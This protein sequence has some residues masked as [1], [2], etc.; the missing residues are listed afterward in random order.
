MIRFGT[1]KSKILQKLTDAYASGN[2][3]EM[4]S[5]LQEVAKNK[6]F[7]DLYLFYEDIENK[8]IGNKEDAELFIEEI[9]P[10]LREQKN[11]SNKF[12][13]ELDKKLGDISITEN[14]VYLFLDK[15]SEN[16][17]LKNVHA[18]INA[19]NKLVEHLMKEK[20]SDEPV[21]TTF[22][23]N[24]NLLHAVL[25]N[26]FNVLY[27]STLNEEEKKLLKEIL[28]I[29]DEDLKNNFDTLKEEVSNKVQKLVSEEKN[30]EVLSKL[31]QV[32]DEM[33]SMTVSKFNYYKLSQLKNG[34]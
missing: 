1:L 9:T 17:T 21:E 13:K 22:A 34:L 3:T 31:T 2:R 25:A 7:R 6:S 27:E 32:V 15:I 18:K 19:K 4:K 20:K 30:T 10:L 26:N 5:L 24:E 28:S 11:R 16:D 29:S 33:Q 23:K 14:T 12:C 8:Y